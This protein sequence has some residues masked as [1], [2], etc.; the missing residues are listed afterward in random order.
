MGRLFDRLRPSSASQQPKEP[1][2]KPFPPERH[3]TGRLQSPL[4]PPPTSPPPRP[5]PAAATS[6]L[7]AAPPQ[8]GA[9]RAP[10]HLAPAPRVP[11]P[12]PRALPPDLLQPRAPPSG[13]A[14]PASTSAG[15]RS[16]L[17]SRQP[18]P[19]VKLDGAPFLLFSPI[20]YFCV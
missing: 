15:F 12:Q 4:P 5:T 16:S 3:A 17:E 10:P 19:F 11:T 6:A 7:S 8:S 9:P 1:D 20:L 2:F 18:S 14:T 13:P